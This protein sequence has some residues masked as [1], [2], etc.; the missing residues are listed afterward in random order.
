[1]AYSS[2]RRPGHVPLED[3]ASYADHPVPARRWI[4]QDMIP[5]GE[6]TLFTG[7]GGTGK[8]L[9]ALQLAV[10]CI[11]GTHFFGK[12]V[13]QG[14]VVIY[15]AEDTEEEYHRR[16]ATILGTLPTHDWP[17]LQGLGAL[18]VADLDAALTRSNQKTQAVEKHPNLDRLNEA[19][20][21]SGAVMCVIDTAAD[22]FPHN[23]NDRREVRGYIAQLR[24]IA[25]ANNCAIVL[26][27]HPSKSAM[28]DDHKHSGS[29]AWRNSVRAMVY[30]SKPKAEPGE[31]THD[32]RTLEVTKANGGAVGELIDLRYSEGVFVHKERPERTDRDSAASK[33][34]RVFMALARKCLDVPDPPGRCPSRPIHATIRRLC[35]PLTPTAKV[36]PKKSLWPQWLGP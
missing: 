31:S 25:R 19:L 20:H 5:Q 6:V 23:E 2:K 35:L 10:A 27:A 9:I 12:S 7:D 26:I 18:H 4:V 30:L 34:D 1:M 17:D 22:T 28:H 11:T 3:A 32:L 16:L 15:N 36:S 29:T 14:S 33:A 8:S 13:N 21:D 24:R